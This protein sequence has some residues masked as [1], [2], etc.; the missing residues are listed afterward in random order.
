TIKGYGSTLGS[1]Q[2]LTPGIRGQYMERIYNTPSAIFDYSLDT[3]QFTQGISAVGDTLTK[4]GLFMTLGSSVA[5]LGYDYMYG[6]G[7]LDT[8]DWFREGGYVVTN[9]VF[10]LSSF[11][12]F[13]DVTAL[14]RLNPI[15]MMF[16][17]IDIGLQISPE[18]TVQF[19]PYAG[20]QVNGWTK[21]MH[22]NADIIDANKQVNSKFDLFKGNKI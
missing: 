2:S 8:G 22:A 5:T 11:D 18:Y 17:A 1:Y 10:A 6:D 15:G 16:T 14:T 20:N 12:Q 13:K 7:R 21:V 4:T 19:G 9:T 3:T